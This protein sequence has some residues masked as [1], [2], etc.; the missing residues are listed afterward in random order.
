MDA[1]KP[2]GHRAPPPP[3]CLPSRNWKRFVAQ[4]WLGVCPHPCP[5][6]SPCGTPS[7][8]SLIGWVVGGGWLGPVFASASVAQVRE[9]LLAAVK[10]V[11]HPLDS[12]QIAVLPP[13]MENLE[14]PHAMLPQQHIP[15]TP[16]QVRNGSSL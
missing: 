14:L 6:S 3:G 5:T 8:V 2:D 7:H 9:W 10:A 16:D 1:F 4:L 12:W 15:I 13:D 11:V